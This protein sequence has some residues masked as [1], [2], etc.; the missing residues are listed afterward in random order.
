MMINKNIYLK[1]NLRYQ[2]EDKF[3]SFKK[4][5]IK[6]IYKIVLIKKHPVCILF[7]I[8]SILF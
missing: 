5:L 2:K 7:L 4:N 8:N 3:S 1:F 6:K